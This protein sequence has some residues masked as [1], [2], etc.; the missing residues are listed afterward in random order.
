MKNICILLNGSIKNDSRV[1][2]L[3]QTFSK[4]NYV[5]LYYINGEYGDEK[6][7]LDNVRLF[8]Y[9]PD[10]NSIKNKIIKH[11]TFYNL[12]LFFAK[13]VT[14]KNVSYDFVYAN[15]LPTLK[16]AYKIKQHF[17]C[18]LI[19]DSHEIY[20]ETLNQFFPEKSKGIKKLIFNVN[21]FLMRYLG[22]KMERKLIKEVDSFVTVSHYVKKYFQNAYKFNN[23]QV[24]YNCPYKQ[25]VNDKVSL[26]NLVNIPSDYR[27][28]LYQ[29]VLNQG[30]SLKKIAEAFKYIDEE[31]ALVILGNGSLKKEL[32][33][34]VIKEGLKNRIFFI[35]K[36]DASVLLNYTRSANAGII[37]QETEKNL[38]KKF[39]IANKLF[40]YMHAGIPFIATDAPEN[41]LVLKK[42]K[43]GI[44][45]D[46]KHDVHEIA[47]A[48]NQVI[49]TPIDEYRQDIAKAVAEYNWNNQEE[50]ILNLVK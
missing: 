48:I 5:D 35:D 11:T 2:K 41:N 6:I 49:N 45:I 24:I 29:G 12:Y 26:H 31:I 23:I 7:F 38:S 25:V 13:E 9:E 22:R 17:G 16:P 34:L 19:Y 43:V 1:I 8:P 37:L 50:T 32:Q 40:E 15:D 33:K 20:I 44:L 36:V 18:K 46:N 21:L 39:G 47:E 42:Y 3:I 28:L 30:R 4:H 10:L 27:I 14:S